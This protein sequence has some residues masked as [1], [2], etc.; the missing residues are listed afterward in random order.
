MNSKGKIQYLTMNM[1]ENFGNSLNDNIT[2]LTVQGIRN[3]YDSSTWSVNIYSVLTDMPAH[4][5]TRAPG[6]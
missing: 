3:C 4:T 5:W 1:Y 6:I 2:N